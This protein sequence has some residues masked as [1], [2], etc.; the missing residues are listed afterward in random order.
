VLTVGYG[1]IHAETNMERFFSVVWMMV[2]VA[3]YSITIG[4]LSS[5]VGKM[6]TKAS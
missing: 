1:D 2:G 4:I 6:D 5:I 3:F